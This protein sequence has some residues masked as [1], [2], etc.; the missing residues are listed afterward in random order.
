MITCK[1][2]LFLLYKIFNTT[3]TVNDM[4]SMFACLWNVSPQA[5]RC[6]RKSSQ[7]PWWRCREMKWLGSSG[8]S[9]R[10]DLSSPTWNSTCTGNNAI[11]G[12]PHSCV[13][14]TLHQ[15]SEKCTYACLLYSNYAFYIRIYITLPFTWGESLPGT[16]WGE[17][18]WVTVSAL[19]GFL[20]WPVYPGFSL[21]SLQKIQYLICKY[22]VHH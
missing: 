16:T 21:W 3:A 11:V 5:A 10:R 12:R 19:L 6:L 13:W 8:S 20:A 4:S 2:V 18:E 14:D 17:T 15:C 7:A 22:R 1:C 9:L